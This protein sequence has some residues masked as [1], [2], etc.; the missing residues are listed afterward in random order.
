MTTAANWVQLTHLC[1][2]GFGIVDMPPH[3]EQAIRY[4]YYYAPPQIDLGPLPTLSAYLHKR[5]FT[6]SEITRLSR[7]AN[8]FKPQL[9]YSLGVGDI[10]VNMIRLFTPSFSLDDVNLRNNPLLD[11][12]PTG[13]ARAF[14]AFQFLYHEKTAVLAHAPR[15]IW[16]RLRQLQFDPVPNGPAHDLALLIQLVGIRHN[17]EN[18][19]ECYMNNIVHRPQLTDAELDERVK[20][21]PLAI[22]CLIDQATKQL[23][24][25]QASST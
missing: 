8:F 20:V 22:Q 12:H 24:E 11:Y 17:I 13:R 19:D 10:N 16:E 18:R 21:F 6:D 14:T 25:A 23:E 5:H 3:V 15:V 7:F 2:G 1:Q 9:Y 4:A